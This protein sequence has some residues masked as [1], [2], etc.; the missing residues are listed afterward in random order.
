[1]FKPGDLVM[2][3]KPTF[4]CGN[5][6]RL[7]DVFVIERISMEKDGECH[8]CKRFFMAGEW[9]WGK[10]WRIY[11]T[12][13]LRLIPPLSEPETTEREVEHAD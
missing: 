9:A 1:M 10:D 4:C 7:G 6:D 3:V 2:V 5:A 8:R 11:V 12:P 13:R